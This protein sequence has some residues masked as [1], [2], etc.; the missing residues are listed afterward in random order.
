[1]AIEAVL[2]L[3][4]AFRRIKGYTN[5]QQTSK[6]QAKAAAKAEQVV[7]KR[8]GQNVLNAIQR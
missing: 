7:W 1:M 2:I 3:E 4:S 5:K 8:K 6:R